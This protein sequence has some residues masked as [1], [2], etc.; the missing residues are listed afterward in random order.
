MNLAISADRLFT[1]DEEIANP[2][3][4][5]R[6]GQIAALGPREEVALP[7]GAEA[8][9]FPGAVILPGMLDLHIH[10]GAGHDL[11]R[12]DEQGRERFERHLFRR[13]VTAYLPTTMTASVEATLKA[14][15]F[16]ADGIEAAGQGDQSTGGG[17]RARFSGRARPLGIHLEGPFISP[18]KA[19]VQPVEYMQAPSPELFERFW[20]AARG[21]IKLMTAAPELPGA[22]E[23]IAIATRRG[24]TISLGHSN[25]DYE[26]ARRGIEAGARHATHTFNA[27]R[28][29][30][31]RA[32]GIAGA[33]LS[34]DRA[35]AEVIADGLHV[36]PAI[37]KLIVRAKG[38]LR[39]VLV[40]DAISA[41]GQGDGRFQLGPVEVQVEGQRC[42]WN[43]HLAGSVLT[44]DRA[45]RNVMEF[46]DLDLATAWRMASANPARMLGL[47]PAHGR[48][49]P[50]A[51]ADLVVANP[52]GEIL[53][54]FGEGRQLTALSSEQTAP[55][56]YY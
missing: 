39:S 31:H 40:T 56:S 16:L 2:I 35:Y 14:I 1:P 47:Q 50:N 34:D 18:E 29:L 32:P 19:G 42:L 25:A 26:T 46:A 24:V 45:V 38:E 41:T 5:I 28:A 30:E 15:E 48:L 20:Q 11:M 36:H 27:M 53:A 43:G 21:H 49:L 4:L 3:L 55:A 22:E 54:V 8:R 52:A 7:G 9:H 10:G 12:P 37:V 13:G 17:A 33:V 6:D 44:L 23:L 51:P